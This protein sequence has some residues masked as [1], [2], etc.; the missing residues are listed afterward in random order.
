MIYIFAVT[1][2]TACFCLDQKRLENNRNGIVPCYQY[3]NSYIR[4]EC[5]KKNF[6][7]D[8]FHIIYDKIIFTKGGKLI[9]VS[10]TALCLTFSMESIFKLEKH[11]DPTWFIPKQTYLYSYLN[12]KGEYYSNQGFEAGLYFG[13]INYTKEI[14]NIKVMSDQLKSS[15][16]I[17]TNV[18]S[19]VDPFREYVFV[20]FKEGILENEFLT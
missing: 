7:N 16:D 19:W 18:L 5:S 1:F 6:T 17:V 12:V 20:N 11:F 3:N 15:D 13:E 2:F 4:N 10:I 8:I 9:V 14:N